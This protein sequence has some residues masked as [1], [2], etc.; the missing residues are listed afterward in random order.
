LAQPIEIGTAGDQFGI[1]VTDIDG[2]SAKQLGGHVIGDCPFPRIDFG[3]WGPF[4]RQGIQDRLKQVGT[5][6]QRQPTPQHGHQGRV[7]G[8]T[9]HQLAR[10]G[11]HLMFEDWS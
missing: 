10:G 7:S 3:G 1:A 11:L 9:R 2:T 6:K 5:R 8:P 4:E